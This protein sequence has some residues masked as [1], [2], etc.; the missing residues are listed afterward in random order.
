[1]SHAHDLV[2]EFEILST[3]SVKFVDFLRGIVLSRDS[4]TELLGAWN[5]E[6]VVVKF[7]WSRVCFA[8]EVAHSLSKIGWV[9]ETN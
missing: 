1:M 8:L 5:L 4:V 9:L 7:H 2:L 3:K 6:R